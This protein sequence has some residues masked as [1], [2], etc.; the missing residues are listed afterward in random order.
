MAGAFSA[1]CDQ[2]ISTLEKFTLALEL[3][4]LIRTRKPART[5]VM[6][7]TGEMMS[8]LGS[9]FSACWNYITLHLL[10]I[11]VFLLYKT[12]LF[13]FLNTG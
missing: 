3:F 11:S 7:T 2:K 8:R 5:F 1:S 4:P 13:F 10:R 9:N 12:F 6:I